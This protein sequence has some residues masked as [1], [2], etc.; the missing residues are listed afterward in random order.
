MNY[1][2]KREAYKIAFARWDHAARELCE[3]FG[4][5]FADLEEHLLQARATKQHADRIAD[6]ARLGLELDQ[7]S[8]QWDAAQRYVL[9]RDL[10]LIDC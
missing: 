9:N 3:L 5:S 10:S 2:L 7:A 8:D 1:L 4:C 6:Y